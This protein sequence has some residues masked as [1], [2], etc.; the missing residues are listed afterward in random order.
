[1]SDFASRTVAQIAAK[2]VSA[3]AAEAKPLVINC[4]QHGF[5]LAAAGF[6][7]ATRAAAEEAMRRQG[8]VF[9]GGVAFCGE[10]CIKEHNF[11]AYGYGVAPIALP[12]SMAKP[13]ATPKPKPAPIAPAGRA[14]I[15]LRPANGGYL[16]VEASCGRCGV[17]SSGI[18]LTE[19]DAH[20]A[21]DRLA[22]SGWVSTDTRHFCGQHC[23]D[24]SELDSSRSPK[25]VEAVTGIGDVH[26]TRTRNAALTKAGLPPMQPAAPLENRELVTRGP[27]PAKA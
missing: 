14:P 13:A 1:M 17:I 15:T 11:A 3:P 25:A 5:N 12:S 27:K 16:E 18:F 6:T 2:A 19:V 20:R 8:N 22:A 9:A 10:N 7:E 24:W 23:R 4:H 21:H 26:Y